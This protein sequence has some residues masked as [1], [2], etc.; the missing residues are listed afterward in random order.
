MPELTHSIHFSELLL[1]RQ[2]R[3]RDAQRLQGR[4]ASDKILKLERRSALRQEEVRGSL[5]GGITDFQDESQ[6]ERGIVLRA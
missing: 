6:K 4:I 3:L 1:R 2:V 5:E